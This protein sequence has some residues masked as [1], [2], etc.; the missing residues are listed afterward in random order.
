MCALGKRTPR[1]NRIHR[2]VHNLSGRAAGKPGPFANCYLG[3]FCLTRGQAEPDETYLWK[4]I[5]TFLL[6][7]GHSGSLL[8]ILS[9]VVLM[10]LMPY[11]ILALGEWSYVDRRCHDTDSS[12]PRKLR[13]CIHTSDTPSIRICPRDFDSQ[14]QQVRDHSPYIGSFLIPPLL[15]GLLKPRRSEDLITTLLSRTTS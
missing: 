9:V 13:D 5:R 10:M 2:W 14:S 8:D 12:C 3:A 15:T 11:F 6:G 4:T 7:A 1:C